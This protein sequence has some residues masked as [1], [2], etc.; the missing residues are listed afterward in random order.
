MSKTVKKKIIPLESGLENNTPFCSVLYETLQP[1]YLCEWCTICNYILLNYV[2]SGGKKN[3]VGESAISCK[4]KKGL[5]QKLK[6]LTHV[7]QIRN[8]LSLILPSTVI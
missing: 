6:L 3:I 1:V 7:H 2:V 8:V 5:I 4:K